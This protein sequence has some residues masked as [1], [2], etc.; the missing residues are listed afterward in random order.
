MFNTK[1][2]Y[3]VGFLP[4]KI[5]SCDQNL[6][7]CCELIELTTKIQG[8]LFSILNL[9]AAEGEIGFDFIYYVFL[10]THGLLH[11]HS[12]GRF[13]GVDT[14]KMRLLPWLGTCFSVLRPSV[15]NDTSLQ[16]IQVKIFVIVLIKNTS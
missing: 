12:G 16:L 10:I 7:K 4:S 11:T 2:N 3:L 5:F 1:I 9:I 6:N 15:T 8:Q 13:D 14:L